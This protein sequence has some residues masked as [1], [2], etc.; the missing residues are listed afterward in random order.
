MRIQFSTEGGLAYFPGLRKPVTIEVADLPE[1]EARAVR[2]LVADANFFDLPP[3]VGAAPRGAA[4]M[5]RHTITVEDAGRRHTV[6]VAEPGGDALGK[7]LGK[8]RLLAAAARRPA[9]S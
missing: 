7:L 4:D 5:Q 8:L 1:G 2:G 9:S 6:R 3:E